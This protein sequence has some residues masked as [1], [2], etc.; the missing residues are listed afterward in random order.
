MNSHRIAMVAVLLYCVLTSCKNEGDHH[1]SPSANGDQPK[2]PSTRPLENILDSDNS[3][4]R[5]EKNSHSVL[6]FESLISKVG[7]QIPPE[8]MKM[9]ETDGQNLPE[10]NDTFFKGVKVYGFGINSDGG[11]IIHIADGELISFGYAF[12]A[13]PEGGENETENH[14]LSEFKLSGEDNVDVLNSNFEPVSMPVTKYAHKT[15]AVI[16]A[17][18]Y[19]HGVNRALAFFDSSKVNASKFLPSIPDAATMDAINK[20]KDLLKNKGK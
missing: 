7:A 8:M 5:L 2:I 4:A 6:K 9:I 13:P 12:K 17:V 15:K 14:F 19:T 18:A 1:G 16:Q 20:T 3:I 11:L 10:M